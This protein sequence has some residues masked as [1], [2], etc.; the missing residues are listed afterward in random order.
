MDPA[1]TPSDFIT[2]AETWGKKPGKYKHLPFYF[3]WEVWLARNRHIFQDAPFIIANTYYA[4]VKWIDGLPPLQE[5]VVDGS[6]RL[7]PH[8]ISIPAFFFDGACADGII[9]CGAWVKLSQGERIHYYWNGGTGTN[10]LAKIMAI[11]DALLA[12]CHLNLPHISFYGDSKLII[13]GL[14]GNIS[15]TNSG[16]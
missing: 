11:W 12:A 15:L 14:M 5:K 9:G 8:E 16:I 3:I 13:D 6:I 7:R 10:N 1:W 2:V 4:I